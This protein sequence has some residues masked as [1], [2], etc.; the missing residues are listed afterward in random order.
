MLLSFFPDINALDPIKWHDMCLQK[1][2]RIIFFDKKIVSL[3]FVPIKSVEIHFQE[4]KK[5]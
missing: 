4:L 1:E 3:C 5:L 2:R